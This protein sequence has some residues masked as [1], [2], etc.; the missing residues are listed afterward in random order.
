MRPEKIFVLHEPLAVLL[1]VLPRIYWLEE[2][3]ADRFTFKLVV[4]CVREGEI[5]RSQHDCINVAGD[6]ISLA[7]HRSHHSSR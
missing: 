6:L 3:R 1:D 5:V 4:L 2:R 7:F